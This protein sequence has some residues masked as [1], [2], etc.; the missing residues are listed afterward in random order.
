[1]RYGWL[2]NLALLIVIGLLAWLVFY[3]LEEEK[4]KEL[5]PL[6]ELKA[7]DIKEIRIK[8]ANQAEIVLKKDEQGFWQMLTPFELP[9]NSFHID[10]LLRILS[11]Q[12]YKALEMEN[13]QLAKFKLEPPLVSVKF[14]DFEVAFGESSP[15]AQG[16]RYVLINNQVYLLLDRLYY[17]T[18]S[19]DALR[20]LS[21]SPLGNNPKL[22]EINTPKYHIV[23]Q[24]GKWTVI[25]GLS[26][27]ITAD[28]LSSL[29]DYWKNASAF[30]IEPYIEVEGT[31]Q[32]EIELKFAD[33]KPALRLK[34]LSTKP[35]LVLARPDKG[36][37][38][39]LPVSLVE[40]LLR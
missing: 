7:T 40:K 17:S 16:Q 20:L 24:E 11:E 28:E 39:Q 21:L 26:S 4:P 5:P 2:I 31:A 33:K 23:L 12:H 29:V 35:D 14:D 9:A 8:K 34:I 27:D 38:Y 18:L 3:T 13:L 30:R 36:V 6:S 22:S 19:H 37:Q 15:I 32:G 10:N 25:S 1:M